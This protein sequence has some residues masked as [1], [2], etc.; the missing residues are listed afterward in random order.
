VL[1]PRGGA[2]LKAASA[3][4][5]AER[6]ALVRAVDLETLRLR[7][8]A[9]RGVVLPLALLDRTLRLLRSVGTGA[10]DALADALARQA[11]EL[12]GLRERASPEPG[13]W[14][15]RGGDRYYSQ[16]LAIATGQAVS[17]Q[18]AHR[19][20]LGAVR[21]MQRRADLLLRE[22]GLRDGSVAERLRSLARDERYLYPA[23]DSGKD[24]AVADMNRWLA[25]ARERLPNAFRDISTAPLS[26][27]RITPQD[28][29]MGRGGSRVDPSFEPSS[30]GLYSVDLR[31]IRRR[32]SWTLP[33][34]VHHELVPGHLLQAPFGG[35]AAPHPLQLRYAGGYSEGWAIYAEQL[36]DELGWMAH[37]P[38]AR[39]GYLQW[40]LFRVGRLVADTGIH[41]MRWSRE[42]AVSELRGIQGDPVAFVTIEDDVDRICAQ[43]GAAAAQALA[44]RELSEL[45]RRAE[46]LLG[47]RFDLAGFH[48]A[49]LRPGP[50]AGP[51]LRRAVE[52]WVDDRSGRA[53][54]SPRGRS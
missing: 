48:D 19:W 11:S 2:Y 17:P 46:S 33:S 6:T 40:M 1:H 4:T 42:R 41:A 45:R 36:A 13:I 7:A 28:E 20:G 30:E 21:A 16:L 5:E 54:S 27:R 10:G 14:R 44:A 8:D 43:P 15:L 24:R 22:Q 32:P 34:V 51:G 12:E 9:G 35:R 38:P 26:V 50:A 49:V 37:D 29:A 18:A 25:A 47:A 53:I 31:T 3:E 39:L 52:L 23:S